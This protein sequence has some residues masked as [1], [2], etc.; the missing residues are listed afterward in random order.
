MPGRSPKSAKVHLLEKEKIYG[1]VKKRLSREPKQRNPN[2]KPKCPSSFT[3][4]ERK[5]WKKIAKILDQYGILNLANGTILNLLVQNISDRNICIERIAD[6]GIC[7]KGR[8]GY[9]FNPFWSAKNK[10]EDNIIK[11]LNLLGLSSMGLAKLGCLQVQSKK[12]KSEMEKLL[13]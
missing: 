2:L 10:C 9:N 4:E 6:D 13:D 3:K 5:I 1:D 7:I 8:Y 11:Y 12:K